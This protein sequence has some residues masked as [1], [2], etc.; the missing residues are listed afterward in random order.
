MCNCTNSTNAIISKSSGQSITEFLLLLPLPLLAIGA[1]PLCVSLVE[2]RSLDWILKRN[3]AISTATFTLEEANAGQWK[4]RSAPDD[5]T[6]T[7][8][9][10]SETIAS[11]IDKASNNGLFFNRK[12]AQL[13]NPNNCSE[14]SPTFTTAEQNNSL[15]IAT[16]TQGTGFWLLPLHPAKPTAHHSATVSS[17]FSPNDPHLSWH[18]RDQFIFSAYQQA[19]PK[20]QLSGFIQYYALPLEAQE[21]SRPTATNFNRDIFMNEERQTGLS[22]GV[23]L[24]KA[25]S[26]ATQMLA[27]TVEYCATYPSQVCPAVGGIASAIASLAGSQAAQTA[28]PHTATSTQQIYLKIQNLAL[29][30]AQQ[31]GIIEAKMSSEL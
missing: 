10:A 5:I 31:I 8:L 25:A 23:A 21:P 6:T 11:N 16:C 30:R 13:G 9:N 24:A 18:L 28:C 20:L 27:C 17:L 2:K 15:T 14:A 26:Q 12:K 3:L 19:I 29:A 7:T 1:I 4:F 22:R